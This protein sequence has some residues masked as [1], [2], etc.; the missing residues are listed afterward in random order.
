LLGISLHGVKYHYD[1]RLF[2]TEIVKYFTYD[3]LPYP[4]E[5]PAYHEVLLELTSNL[6]MKRFF[7]LIDDLFFVLGVAK[8][9]NRN[10]LLV[11]TFTLQTQLSN[12]FAFFS[13]MAREGALVVLGCETGFQRERDKQYHTNSSTIK[14]D[15]SSISRSA[16]LNC[17]DLSGRHRFIKNTWSRGP[18]FHRAR[19]PNLNSP[20]R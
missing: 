15:G 6:A 5:V 13:R 7:H 17:H 20:N 8:V 4:E 11:R 9:L 14:W 10:A 16:C 2:P 12:M 18:E 19:N 3:I 1:K